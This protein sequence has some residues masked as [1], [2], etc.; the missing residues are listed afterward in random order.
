MS[1]ANEFLNELNS[2][3]ITNKVLDN[4]NNLLIM[5]KLG[6]GLDNENCIIEEV[7]QSDYFRIINF[8]DAS[9]ITVS[10]KLEVKD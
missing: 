2:I 1:I 4:F 6:N 7:I 3:R 9:S 8:K 5:W 10:L